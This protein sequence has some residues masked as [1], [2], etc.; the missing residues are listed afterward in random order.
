MRD[1]TMPDIE[2]IFNSCGFINSIK[3][4]Y[5]EAVIERN[6]WFMYGSKKPD[7]DNP[8][9]LSH[10]FS[11]KS[12][13]IIEVD[14][15]YES[16][17]LIDMFSIRN[18]FDPNAIK[19]DIPERAQS[20]KSLTSNNKKII[21]ILDDNYVKELVNILNPIRAD[22]YNDWLSLGFCLHNISY[23]NLP[24]W[25]EFSKN[26]D[27]YKDGECDRLWDRMRDDGLNIGTLYFWAKNDNPEAYQDIISRSVFNDIKI[28]N[29]SHESIALIAQKILKHKYAC[30]T[31]DGKTWYM[32]NGIIWKQDF[33]ELNLRKDLSTTVRNYYLHTMNSILNSLSTNS[34]STDKDARKNTEHLVKISFKLQDHF[35]KEGILKEMRVLF[36]KENFIKEL[37]SN[38]NL[39]GFNNGV[40]CLK[41]GM[42]RTTVPD[43]LIS[44]SVGYDYI[45]DCD[46]SLRTKV[47]Q[48]FE[49]L[50]PNREQRDYIIK[51]LAKQL[52]GDS[53]CELLH[54]HAG[55]NAS[56]GNGKSVFFNILELCLG[57]YIKKFPVEILV[58]KQRNE[59][60]KPMPEF[61]YWKGTRI[62][63]CTEPNADDKIN[64]GIMKELTGGD[65]IQFRMLYS[66]IKQTFRPMFKISMMCNDA[67]IIEGNDEG[68]K[69]RIRKID[70]I[71]KFVD[72][73]NIDK[74]NHCYEK[75]PDFIEQFKK[76]P[77][78]KLEFIRFILDH[79]NHTYK[80][81]MPDIIKESSRVYLEENN[82]VLNFVKEFI[83]KDKDG[84]FTLKDA[85]D[86]FKNSQY[87]NG[88]IS[89]LKNELQ[90]ILKTICLEQKKINNKVFKYIF[91]GYNIIEYID[92]ENLDELD[93]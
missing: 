64:S 15:V 45:E 12:R 77:Q 25:I 71:S 29:G 11:W 92:D 86:K 43:D 40:W 53:G 63:Y 80:F 88:K 22:N 37:D 28:C 24:I 83:K 47:I 49:T 56:A 10:V 62:M 70:Y 42:F 18:K 21:P 31:P 7:E 39:I 79:Y 87:F 65:L 34:S 90:K 54:I 75:D 84:Y 19:K 17:E 13:N 50:H 46:K 1:T 23:N 27:K 6:N 9:K 60:H 26:S 35:F 68:I 4:I 55:F 89:N 91:M 14:N 3:D 76:D 52:Y 93:M 59:P 5:D 16:D 41:E 44:F 8:W 85:K 20:I 57:D 66:N 81:E 58:C 73:D 38:P 78:L 61:S 2:N 30:V 36:Y 51:T 67:P 82:N 69:R 48:Y 33:S 72:R 32:F 74:L